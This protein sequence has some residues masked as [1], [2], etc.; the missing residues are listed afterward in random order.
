MRVGL[1]RVIFPWIFLISHPDRPSPAAA[2][3]GPAPRLDG[4]AWLKVS[5]VQI[6]A[7][8]NL[9]C[10][11][12][13]LQAPIIEGRL[14]RNDEHIGRR[15]TNL[16]KPTDKGSIEIAFGLQC[17]PRKQVHLDQRVVFRFSG[18]H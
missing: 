1:S 14:V 11:Q 2:H 17:P 12:A 15:N 4:S 9:G 5:D 8:I 7:K 3:S 16:G 18:E 13:S 6:E 10:R